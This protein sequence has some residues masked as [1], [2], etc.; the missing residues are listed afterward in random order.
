MT[1]VVRHVTLM[2]STWLGMFAAAGSLAR[3]VG[4]LLVTEIYQELGS[5]WMLGI[6]GILMVSLSLVARCGR[7]VGD[8]PLCLEAA[9]RYLLD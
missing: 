5:Y 8:V 6:V 3:V 7:S 4:P 1:R 9:T 2:Q